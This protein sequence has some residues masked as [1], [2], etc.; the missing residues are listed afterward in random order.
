MQIMSLMRRSLRRF[1]ADQRGAMPVEGLLAFTFLA[2]WYAASFQFFDALEQR[3]VNLKAAYTVADLMS[4]ETG[5]DPD[6]PTKVAIDDG[7]VYGLNRVFDYL[8]FSNRPTWIRVSSVYWD[9]G[10]NRFR[11][12]WSYATGSGHQAQSDAT[13]QTIAG[14]I[15]AMSVGD[16]A[17]VMETFMAYEPIFNVGL[18]ARWYDTLIVTRPR[19]AACIPWDHYACGSNAGGPANPDVITLDDGDYDPYHYGG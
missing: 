18:A 1:A 13:L 4:R 6:D 15:P 2:W 12:E 14:R 16:S 10:Q 5:P 17:I 7:Y 8:T 11:V 19:F 9:A 3:N